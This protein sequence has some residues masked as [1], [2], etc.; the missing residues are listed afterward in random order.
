ML[1]RSLGLSVIVLSSANNLT[2]LFIGL[3]LTRG[4]G[5]ASL[6]VVSITIVSNSHAKRN[7]G[8]AMAFYAILSLPFHLVLINSVGYGLNSLEWNWRW[9]TTLIGATVILLSF[10]ALFIPKFGRFSRRHP[11]EVSISKGDLEGIGIWDAL[12]TPAFWLFGLTISIW[13]MIYSGV[14][15][16]N[17]DIFHERGFEKELYFRILSFTSIVGLFSKF[18]FGWAMR[19]LSVSQLLGISM[20]FT[21]LSLVGLPLASETWHAYLYGLMGGISSGGIALLFF[22]CWGTLYGHRD[23]GKI[24][25]VA[26]SLTILASAIGP[27][28]FSTVKASMNSYR[29]VFFATAGIACILAMLSFVVPTPTDSN[30][31]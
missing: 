31:S 23:L 8:L 14:A 25:G 29:P 6:S 20:L 11:A 22:S 30:Q 12:A 18:V 21:S 9:V 3:L 24:Q 5:Q 19:Y 7:L 26:Q 28:L 10:S 17:Q 15:L 16:F 4:F 1:F 2:Q 27:V 13:G